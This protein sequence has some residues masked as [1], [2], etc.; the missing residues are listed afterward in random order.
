[1]AKA[2]VGRPQPAKPKQARPIPLWSWLLVVPLAVMALPSVLLLFVAMMPTL[3]AAVTDRRPEKYAAMCVG[4]FNL[5][6]TIPYLIQLWATSHSMAGFMAFVGNVWAWLIIYSAA[7]LGWGFV[8]LIPSLMNRL[9][10]WMCNRD[11]TK[12]RRRQ[13]ELVDEWGV[14]LIEADQDASS[15]TPAPARAN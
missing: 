6:A 12:L 8:W 11:L 15:L 7:A 14:E 1:M 13:Q 10:N 3:A 5:A 9:N 2:L 4:G